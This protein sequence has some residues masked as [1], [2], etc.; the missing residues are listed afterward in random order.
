MQSGNRFASRYKS[1]VTGVRKKISTVSII[2][3]FILYFMVAFAS[4][5]A[6]KKSDLTEGILLGEHEDVVRSRYNSMSG[7][8]QYLSYSVYQDF[9]DEQ[10]EDLGRAW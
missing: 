7:D 2:L 10:M 1:E 4:G 6:N 9:T 3:P 8:T 5:C